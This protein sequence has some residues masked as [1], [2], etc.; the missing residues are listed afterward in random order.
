MVLK[1]AK[2]IPHREKVSNEGSNK[3]TVIESQ[4]ADF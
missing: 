2:R 1:C 4:L 3:K